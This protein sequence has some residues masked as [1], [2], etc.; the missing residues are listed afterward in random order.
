ML[1]SANLIA[2]ITNRAKV[3]KCVVQFVSCS[4]LRIAFCRSN[5]NAEGFIF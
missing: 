5:V 3:T 4:L 1:I 2:K